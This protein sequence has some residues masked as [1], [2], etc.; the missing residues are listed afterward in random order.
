[1]R[2]R[3]DAGIE[4]P[5]QLVEPVNDTDLPVVK[6]DV[7]SE[8]PSQAPE[9]ADDDSDDDS[10]V[11]PRGRSANGKSRRLRN[12]ARP[13]YNSC[14]IPMQVRRE[15]RKRLKYKQRLRMRREEGD[16][17][18]LQA[19]IEAPS[20]KTLMACPLSKFIHFA[21][22]DCGYKGT[23]RELICNWVHPFFLKAK[24]KA[25]KEDNPNWKQAMNG[26][27]SAEYWKAAV[28]EFDTLQGMDAWDIVDRTDDMN[29]IDSIWAFKCKRYPDGLIK[30]FKA[31]FCARGDQQLEGIDF[32]ETYAPVVQ[33][34]TVRLL[35]ILEIL[36]NLK[37]KQGDV[38]AAFLHAPLE[39]EKV[40]VE[41]PLGFKE[42][43]KVL[44]LKR[45]L[46]GLKQSP[47]YFWKYLTKAMNACGLV[48]SKLDP[49]LFVGDRVVAIAYVDDI[50]FW[51][52]DEK[53]IIELAEQLRLQGLLLEQEDDAAGF[54]GVRLTK[55]DAGLIEMKQTGLIDRVIVL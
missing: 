55:T 22:N 14:Q 7:P 44:S 4:H 31:R 2:F 51:S 5:R 29:V 53:H 37:S 38:T 8:P 46:Y 6:A 30:K 10:S 47:R 3:C 25:S 34:T 32:F 28:K 27:F 52:K 16:K 40:F 35:L 11:D 9:G 20:I 21:A 36:L 33:W 1:M 39:D 43:G 12:V 24:S 41:M 13:R 42:P 50:L 45:S 49:C 48:T 26:P 18:M 17:L 23:R 54:L 19:D 15:S